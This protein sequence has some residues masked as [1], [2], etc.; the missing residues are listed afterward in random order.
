MSTQ[1]F[2]LILG[3]VLAASMAPLSAHH[4]HGNYAPGWTPLQGTVTEVHYL[5]PHSW[6]Y[7]EVKNAKGEIVTWALEA[8]A[9]SSLDRVG[10]KRDIVKPGDAIK[11]SCRA[12]R[13]GTP[14]CLLGTV[15]PLHGDAKRANGVPRNW[16]AD[17]NANNPGSGEP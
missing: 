6:I 13:D 12:L 11:A 14:G 1:L 5:T 17:E 4:S 9:G 8:A 10:I 15:T 2:R 7:L 16:D 3:I